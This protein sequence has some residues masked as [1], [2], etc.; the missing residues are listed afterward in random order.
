MYSDALGALGIEAV[1]PEAADFE[2]VHRIIFAELVDG[3][4][5]DASRQAYNRAIARLARA[6][7][8]RGGPRVHGDPAARP[9]RRVSPAHAR[10]HPHTRPR[11]APGSA[12]MSSAPRGSTHERPEPWPRDPSSR[13]AQRQ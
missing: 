12:P 7:L 11:C 2:T 8:R 9:S 13:E 5:T 6:R 3:V 10:L 4:F 1:V